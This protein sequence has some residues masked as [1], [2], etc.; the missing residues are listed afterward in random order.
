MPCSFAHGRHRDGRGARAGRHQPA[1]LRAAAGFACFSGAPQRRRRAAVGLSDAVPSCAV[2]LRLDCPVAGRRRRPPPAARW[3]GRPGP[4]AAGRPARSTSDET[5]GLNRAGRRRA[6]RPRRPPRRRVMA[7]QRAGWLRCRL[8][9]AAEAD[10]PTYTRVPGSAGRH[11][12]H[13]RRHGADGARRGGAGRGARPL[14]RHARASASRCSAARW[15]PSEEP[16]RAAGRHGEDGEQVWRQVQHFAESEPRRQALPPRPRTPARSA[17]RRP[18]ARPTAGCATT[19]RCR[20]PGRVAPAGEL[21]HRRRARR[22]RGA[23][24]G[25]GAQDERPVRGPGGEPVARRSGGAEAET[26]ED[27]QDA[28]PAAAALPRPGGDG[29]GLRA[30]R[31]RGG[32]RTPPACTASPRESRRARRACGCS[33]CRTWPATRWAGCGARTCSP[34]EA[35]LAA[36]QRHPRRAAAGRHPAARGSRPTTPG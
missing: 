24:P 29:R 2:L 6:A 16:A 11:R 5:G 25:P 17:R 26:L 22:E 12:V 36:D 35:T 13:H 4:A 32:A 30:A 28:R 7:R 8:V 20:R 3:C 1:A 21:P 19:A 15:C 27:A 23:G 18:S 14:R 9:D 34:P 31:P 33:S 10:Q